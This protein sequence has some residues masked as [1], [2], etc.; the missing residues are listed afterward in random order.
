MFCYILFAGKLNFYSTNNN[1]YLLRLTYD[2][3]R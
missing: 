1:D 2:D 3:D